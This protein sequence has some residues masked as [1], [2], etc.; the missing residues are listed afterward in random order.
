MKYLFL[1]FLLSGVSL[2]LINNFLQNL[3]KTGVR[4][5]HGHAVYTGKYGTV[6]I[7]FM[8]FIKT[9]YLPVYNSQL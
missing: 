3:L 9:S 7:I 2:K 5:T 1:Y 4:I 8:K 6:N